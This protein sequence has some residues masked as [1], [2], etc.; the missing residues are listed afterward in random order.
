[1]TRQTVTVVTEARFHRDNSGNIVCREG[2]RAYAFWTRY[3]SAFSAVR[4]IARVSNTKAVGKPVE[5]PF[6][7]VSA[8]QDVQ[9]VAE[10]ARRWPRVLGQVARECSRPSS[11]LLRLP[12]VL[13]S[14]AALTLR[15]RNQPYAVELVGD[16]YDVIVGTSRNP[17]HRAVA[18]AASC[19]VGLDCR[20]AAAIAYV[21]ETT[22]QGRYPPAPQAVTGTYSSIAL[23]DEWL[24]R[25]ARRYKDWRDPI[26]S[27]EIVRVVTV[28]RLNNPYKGVDVLLQALRR[29]LDGGLR[30]ELTIVGDGVLRPALE[31]RAHALGVAEAAVFTG[32]LTSGSEI[33]QSLQTADLFVLASTAEGL[34]RALIE[35]MAQALPCVATNVGG[36]PELL[37]PSDLVQAGDP[38]ALAQKIVE[39]V[40]SRERLE[41]MSLRNVAVAQRYLEKRLMIRRDEFYR[42]TAKRLTQPTTESQPEETAA[43]NL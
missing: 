41:E 25:H 6:V 22:L 39:V 13:G 31:N 2:G 33:R 10:W 36:V 4:I 18:K 3:L 19:H 9:G 11:Y 40:S 37:P 17:V 43:A 5:G 16:I 27:R 20:R 14:T 38:I 1:V 8:I 23:S 29:I 34:P 35:A 26:R 7:V 21:T 42:A 30:V 32:Q 28:G 15:R 24:A 12:G